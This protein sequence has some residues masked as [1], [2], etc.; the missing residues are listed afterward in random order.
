[1]KA[2]NTFEKWKRRNERERKREYSVNTTCIFREKY[3]MCVRGIL[4][5]GIGEGGR[6]IWRRSVQQKEKDNNNNTRGGS[7]GKDSRKDKR[8]K[9]PPSCGGTVPASQ[10]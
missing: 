10:C 5:G 1:M 4:S 8:Q 2:M 3:G 9:T 6:E 7:G